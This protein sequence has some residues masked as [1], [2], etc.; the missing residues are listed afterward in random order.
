MILQKKELGCFYDASIKLDKNEHVIP[1]SYPK[2]IRRIYSK[3]EST[4]VVALREKYLNLLKKIRSIQS[5]INKTKRLKKLDQ[6]IKLINHLSQ[7]K[8]VLSVSQNEWTCIFSLLFPFVGPNM[9]FRLI[10]KSAF[11]VFHDYGQRKVFRTQFSQIQLQKKTVYSFDKLKL[12]CWERVKHLHIKKALIYLKSIHS[13]PLHVPIKLK[14]E[15]IKI[16]ITTFLKL[17]QPFDFEPKKSIGRLQDQTVHLLIVLPMLIYYFDARPI[18]YIYAR[19][20]AENKYFPILDP[21]YT[22]SKMT[23]KVVSCSHYRCLTNFKSYDVIDILK[24]LRKFFFKDIYQ[25]TNQ[26]LQILPKDKHF[27]KSWYHI[28]KPNNNYD[29]TV[30]IPQN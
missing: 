7:S 3:L 18:F 16:D 29:R 17:I 20:Y 23:I 15:N 22:N 28:M 30:Y 24:W 21:F 26:S 5:E 9:T 10:C 1:S 14:P 11:H 2:L 27:S 19:E 4:Q 25:Y 6:N 13:T 12:N 8:L